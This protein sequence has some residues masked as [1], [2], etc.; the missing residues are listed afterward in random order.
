[1]AFYRGDVT[2]A[3]TLMR[4]VQGEGP[5]VWQLESTIGDLTTDVEQ[6]PDPTVRAELEAVLDELRQLLPRQAP[7]SA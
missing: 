4:C 7:T 5:G 2:A 6:Q 1:M 3:R